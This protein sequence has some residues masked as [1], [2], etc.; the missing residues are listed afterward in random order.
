MK[1]DIIDLLYKM[2]GEYLSGEEMADFLNMTRANVWKYIKELRGHGFDIESSTKKGYVL[3]CVGKNLNEDTLYYH[4]KK[5]SF[6][7]EVIFF[8]T[9]DSTN[10][11]LKYH[12]EELEDNTL[13]VAKRQMKGRGRRT[14]EFVSDE[15]G[16]YF[17]FLTKNNMEMKEV[18]FVTSIAAVAVHEALCDLGVPTKI[19]WPN[20]I[21]LKDKKLCGI[22]TEMVT[23]MEQS[24][25]IIIG[26]GINVSN[27]FPKELSMIATSLSE[28]GY[29]IEEVTLLQKIFE[30]F[31]EFYNLFLEGNTLKAL[32]ILRENSYL[33]GKQIRF[34]KENTEYTGTVTGIEENGNLTVE[35][36]DGECVF[37]NS[38][39]VTILKKGQQV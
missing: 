24:N 7:N 23:D 32:E 8:E 5:Q 15:G 1:R 39:E 33:F 11:F 37:L 21:I 28:N 35:T 10:D 3:S 27:Q 6:V 2:N 25:Q 19:K 30:R 14:R 16:L 9:I 22:L 29:Q 18:A 20:D 36:E 34:L 13:V 38:G 4:F 31:D 17:S 12:K 26:I